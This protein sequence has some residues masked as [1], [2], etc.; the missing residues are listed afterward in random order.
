MRL[1]DDELIPK[2]TQNMPLRLVDTYT[3]LI[4]DTYEIVSQ[5]K[6]RSEYKAKLDTAISE[7]KGLA[8]PIANLDFPSER[9]MFSELDDFI[10]EF[11]A[12]VMFSHRWGRREPL[13]EDVQAVSCGI[14]YMDKEILEKETKAKKGEEEEEH[15]KVHPFSKEKLCDLLAGIQKLQEFCCVAAKCG[16]RWAWSDTCCINKKDYG[17]LSESLNSMFL[18]Y[19]SSYLTVVYLG[20]ADEVEEGRLPAVE[21]GDREPWYEDT[22]IIAL[23]NSFKPQAPSDTSPTMP[24]MP[25]YFSLHERLLDERFPQ[26]RTMQ[27][28]AQVEGPSLRDYL[29]R[30]FPDVNECKTKGI[31][32]KLPVWVTRG[33][34]LQETLAS[35]RLRFY[36]KQWTLLEEANDDHTDDAEE[37]ITISSFKCRA[38]LVDH[39]KNSIWCDAL[40]RTTGIPHTDLIGFKVGTRDVQTR[41]SWMS[42]RTT[43]KVEDMSYC[44]LGIF[45]IS[46]PVLYGEGCRAFLRLQD[47]IMKHTGDMSLFNWSGRGSSFNSFLADNPKCFELPDLPKLIIKS[48]GSILRAFLEAFRALCAGVWMGVTHLIRRLTIWIKKIFESPLPGHAL[49]N[50]ELSLPLFEH[51]V[52]CCE[53]VERSEAGDRYF[54]YKLEAEGLKDTRVTFASKISNLETHPKQYYVCR[55][56]SRNSKNTLEILL[57]ILK[58]K[59][60]DIF[61]R[62]ESES[63]CPSRK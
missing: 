15:V 1:I 61:N 32:R 4:F 60:R 14:Y 28:D 9:P 8:V 63:E 29:D 45:G 51:R 58:D 38:R 20:D 40:E 13:L 52:R 30:L 59:F 44:L 3:G 11:L 62:P 55:L 49:V 43:T 34:T 17:E 57:G 5:L 16:F 22:E 31:Y 54:H 18:W 24:Q 27:P 50:G 37:K 47:E 39:R 26:L 46:L 35:K 48:S 56:W 53:P 6:M 12:F 19:R 25:P 21:D 41:L 36:S 23:S 42:K 7:A 10:A 33:W 2:Y